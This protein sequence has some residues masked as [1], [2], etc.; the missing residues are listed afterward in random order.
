MVQNL[1]IASKNLS[2][3]FSSGT[4]QES[5]V[6][7]EEKYFVYLIT[8]KEEMIGCNEKPVNV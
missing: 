1:N 8:L 4:R 6:G 7:M 2:R 5:E 3:S